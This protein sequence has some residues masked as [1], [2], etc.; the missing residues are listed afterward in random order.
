VDARAVE[1]QKPV[2]DGEE[3]LRN[4]KRQRHALFVQR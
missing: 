3:L 4:R 2:L 1:L